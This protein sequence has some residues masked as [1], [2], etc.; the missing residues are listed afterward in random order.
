MTTVLKSHSILKKKRVINYIFNEWI[1]QKN[2]LEDRII[3]TMNPTQRVQ[4]LE[5][6]E[7]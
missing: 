1:T 2:R 7:I 3:A 4:T 6:E 5:F